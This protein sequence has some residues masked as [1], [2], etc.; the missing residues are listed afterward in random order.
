[1]S[2]RAEDWIETSGPRALHRERMS[3]R[4]GDWIETYYPAWQSAEMQCPR[5]GDWIETCK[6]SI[7]L[8]GHQMSPTWGP[9]RNNQKGGVAKTS[10]ECP[11]HGGLD[12]NS[13]SFSLLVPYSY[14]PPCGGLDRNFK[15]ILTATAVFNVPR[16]RDWIGTK[17]I[18]SAVRTKYAPRAGD[19]IETRPLR[20]SSHSQHNVPP[21]GGLDRNYKNLFFN[22][23]T[24]NVPRTGD[25]IETAG[26]DLY[27]NSYNVSRTGDRIETFTPEQDAYT[28]GCSPLCRGLDRNEKEGLSI[29]KYLMSPARGTG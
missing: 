24:A 2:P 6:H 13:N 7:M 17:S 22:A 4:A 9:D 5:T 11:P 3:P 12:R 23:W 19:W 21:C 15:E 8:I 27:Y 14:V 28:Q 10:N 26:A 29:S 16:A 20:R 18:V 25:W 1:M